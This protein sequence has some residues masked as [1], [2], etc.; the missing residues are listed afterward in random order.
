MPLNFLFIYFIFGCTESLLLHVGY[1][2]VAMHRAS[3]CGGFSCH[4][5]WALG[6]M[7]LS[8]WTLRDSGHWSS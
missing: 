8:G 7:G 6:R 2:L 3:H 5:V 1:S 4:G